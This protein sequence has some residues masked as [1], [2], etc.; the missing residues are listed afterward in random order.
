MLFFNNYSHIVYTGCFSCIFKG[1][2]CSNGAC[3][4]RNIMPEAELYLIE[5]E[6]CILINWI[7]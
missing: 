3:V 1:G 5:T 6:D 2:V 4:L 7:F